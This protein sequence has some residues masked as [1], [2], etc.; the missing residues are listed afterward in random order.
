VGFALKPDTLKRV[1][2]QAVSTVR[3]NPGSCTALLQAK[4][5]TRDAAIATTIGLNRGI[6]TVVRP[7]L[8]EYETRDAE[9]Y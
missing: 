7:L 8:A 3:P 4:R 6:V 5:S 2:T 9:A 1:E